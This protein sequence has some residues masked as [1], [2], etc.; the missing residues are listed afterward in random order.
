ELDENE[1]DKDPSR[2]IPSWRKT[3]RALRTQFPVSQ[4]V[5]GTPNIANA[6]SAP[7][8]NDGPLYLGK[9]ASFWLNR[10]DDSSEKFRVEAIQ[11]IGILAAKDK[12]LLPVIVKALDDE[13]NV[14]REALFATA[15]YAE[16]DKSLIPAIVKL[17]NR[18]D[19]LATFASNALSSL[20]PDVV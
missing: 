7:A 17:L 8:V 4:A 18:E 10:F 5:P 3:Y 13:Y 19:E 9:P 12:S 11:A 16:K 1:D 6:P 20:G 14:A 2:S 15:K